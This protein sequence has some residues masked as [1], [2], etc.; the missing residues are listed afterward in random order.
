VTN[1]PLPR[2]PWGCILYTDRRKLYGDRRAAWVEGAPIKGPVNWVTRRCW[3]ALGR[4]GNEKR[5]IA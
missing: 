3:W 5:D 2:P 4:R 1:E